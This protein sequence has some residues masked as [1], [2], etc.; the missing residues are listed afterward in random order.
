MT[1]A[2]LY[3]AVKL[4]LCSVQVNAVYVEQGDVRYR[5]GVPFVHGWDALLE[6]A[7]PI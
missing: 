3:L 6:V 2:E 1:N 4:T 5:I 7:R